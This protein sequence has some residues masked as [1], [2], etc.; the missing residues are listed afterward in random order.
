MSNRYSNLILFSLQQD[1]HNSRLFVSPV[2]DPL[3]IETGPMSDKV[4]WTGGDSRFPSPANAFSVPP[5][6]LLK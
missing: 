6:R 2:P 5:V 1:F 4:L 3:A